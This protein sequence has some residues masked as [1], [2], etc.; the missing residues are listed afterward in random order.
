M[1]E[2]DIKQQVLQKLMELMQDIQANNLRPKS[3][4]MEAPPMDASAEMPSNPEEVAGQ[5]I[6]PMEARKVEGESAESESPE[7]LDRLR[8]MYSKLH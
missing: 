4:E 7:M 6:S 5:E 2:N 8:D 1:Q 3:P